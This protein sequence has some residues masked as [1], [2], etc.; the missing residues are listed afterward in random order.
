MN[1]KEKYIIIVAGGKG[2]RMGVSIPKQFLL[3]HNKPILMHTIEAFHSYDP[4]IKII[5]VLP[6]NQQERWNELCS[7]YGFTI[8][9]SIVSGGETRFHSVKNAL[10]LLPA[11]KDVLVGIHDGVRPLI[12]LPVI[13]K[14][15]DTAEEYPA[16]IPVIP[17]SDSIRELNPSSGE[18][19]PV[20]RQYYR[21]VQT[22]QVFQSKILLKAYSEPYTPEFTD[23]ASVAGKIC[24]IHLT[25]GNKENIKIT[26]REDLVIAEAL[27]SFNE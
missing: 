14:C 7:E 9:H 2:E 19:K 21:L 24:S 10:S 11:D 23:D 4:E 20:D 25:D 5:I 1:A 12:S 22:P 18:S 3:L 17:V 16:V 8:T 15:F 13:K 27:F 26:T 6:E